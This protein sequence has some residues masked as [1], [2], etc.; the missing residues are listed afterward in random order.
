MLFHHIACIQ[1]V[2]LVTSELYKGVFIFAGY[3]QEGK[4]KYFL[5]EV[6]KVMGQDPF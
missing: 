2:S 5:G 6:L 1:S 4:E 3:W